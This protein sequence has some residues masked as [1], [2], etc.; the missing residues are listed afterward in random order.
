MKKLVLYLIVGL[1]MAGFNG[2][3]FASSTT[4]K[5]V[6]R[7]EK[8]IG[9]CIE[10]CKT[11]LKSIRKCGKKCVRKFGKGIQN[12]NRCEDILVPVVSLRS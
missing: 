3:G 12:F 5:E 7:V 8:C 6:K 2:I 11:S 9:S 1:F 4:D 10:E